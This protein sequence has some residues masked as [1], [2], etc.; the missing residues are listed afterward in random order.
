[1][2][3]EEIYK[4]FDYLEKECNKNNYFYFLLKDN[5]IYAYW[6]NDKLFAIFYPDEILNVIKYEEENK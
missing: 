2:S 6:G 3:Q 5:D 4:V 1:M